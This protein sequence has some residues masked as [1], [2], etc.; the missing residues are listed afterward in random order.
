MLLDGPVILWAK[1]PSQLLGPPLLGVEPDRDR[2]DNH[3]RDKE[4]RYKRIVHVQHLSCSLATRAGSPATP[5]SGVPVSPIAKPDPF[6]PNS[7][8]T[9]PSIDGAD[10]VENA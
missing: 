3:E 1:P 8:W 9:K 5:C 2:D 6:S 7:L 4:D 10:D